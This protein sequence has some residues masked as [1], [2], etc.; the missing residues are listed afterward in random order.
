[1]KKN[2]IIV[3]LCAFSIAQATAND[4]MR[5]GGMLTYNGAEAAGTADGVIPTFTGGITKPPAGYKKGGDHID[6]YGD[7]A[8]LYTITASNA[9]K[10]QER[11]SAGQQ[12]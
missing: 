1:M 9:D 10:Y 11:L 3:S 6:P 8:P 2:I 4:A 12:A 5:L 7:D